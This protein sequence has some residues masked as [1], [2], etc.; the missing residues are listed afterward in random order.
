MNKSSHKLM[1]LNDVREKKDSELI[2]SSVPVISITHVDP[3]AKLYYSA[4]SVPANGT[5][6]GQEVKETCE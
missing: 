1:R 5:V 3:E 6:K 4:P 2:W